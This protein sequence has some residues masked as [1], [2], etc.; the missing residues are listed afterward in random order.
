MDEVDRR[1]LELKFGGLPFKK[2]SMLIFSFP[3]PA[4]Q[5]PLKGRTS[6]W[7]RDQS[8]R[9]RINFYG[10][11]S[12][13]GPGRPRLSEGV[14]AAGESS[15]ICKSGI[16]VGGGK[17]MC[18]GLKVMCWGVV[19]YCLTLIPP[20]GSSILFNSHPPGNTPSV[21]VLTN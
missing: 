8:R 13:I 7:V 21:T 18:W 9:F 14:V 10:H 17:V 4:R 11:K 12:S 3:P 6:H 20:G 5:R 16:Y 2:N 19:P 1:G 15:F